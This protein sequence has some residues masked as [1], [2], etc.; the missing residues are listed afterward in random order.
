[1]LKL[2]HRL[3]GSVEIPGSL[4]ATLG[5]RQGRRGGQVE[6]HISK[7]AEPILSLLYVMVH[8]KISFEK[9]I[10]LK[11]KKSNHETKNITLRTVN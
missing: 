7:G 2:F 11:E 8:C 4:E 5:N 6:Q 3:Q 1:M 10:L 9:L